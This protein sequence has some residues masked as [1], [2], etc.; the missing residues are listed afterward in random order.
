MCIYCTKKSNKTL[1]FPQ[2][3][4]IKLI[5]CGSK[6]VGKTSIAIRYHSGK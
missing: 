2:H 3:K 5:I 6:G 4:G 1:N